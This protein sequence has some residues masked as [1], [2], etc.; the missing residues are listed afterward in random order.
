LKRSEA[1][2]LAALEDTQAQRFNE[3][4]T[5][6]LKGWQLRNLRGKQAAK[7]KA[8]VEGMVDDEDIPD[9]PEPDP[10]PANVKGEATS[11]TTAVLTWTP[12]AGKIHEVGRDPF[13]GQPA[14]WSQQVP[15]TTGMQAFT[16][17]APGVPVVLWVRVVGGERVAVTVTPTG[18]VQP[19]PDEP[20]EPDEPDVPEPPVPPVGDAVVLTV[21][22]GAPTQQTDVYALGVCSSGYG[23]TPV[24][25]PEQAAAERQLD[26]RFWRLPVRLSGDGTQVINSAAG[27]GGHNVKPILD[28]Y[29]SWGH[30]ALIVCAGR[31]ADDW[32]TYQDGD[33]GRIRAI[34]GTDQVEFTGPN[35]IGLRGQDIG[36][37]NARVQQMVAETGQPIGGP[38]WTHYD[39]GTL[40]AFMDALPADKVSTVD[41][42]NYAMGAG[43]IPPEQALA[44]TPDWGRQVREVKADMDARGIQGQPTI[45]ELNYSWRFNT[46]EFFTAVN[47]V[48]MA[49]ALGH[50]L[51]NGGRGMPYATQNGALGVTVEKPPGAENPDN[52]PLSSPMP[53]FWGIAAWTGAQ[54]F[55]H[56]KD[57]FY[58]ATSPDPLVEVFAVSNEAGGVN[59]LVINKHAAAKT[60]S[61]PGYGSAPRWTTDPAKPYDPPAQV[62]GAASWTQPG[63]SWSV[64][65]VPPFQGE[66]TS[67]GRSVNASGLCGFDYADGKSMFVA[68]WAE[69]TETLSDAKAIGARIVRAHTFG[70]TTFGPNCL[71]RADGALNPAVVAAQDWALAEAERLGIRLWAVGT[72]NW[73]WWNGTK[74]H[75]SQLA[76]GGDFYSAKVLA[77]YQRHWGEFLNRRNPHTGKLYKDHAAFAVMESGNELYGAPEWWTAQLAAF[78]HSVAPGV[79][80]ADGDTE[81]NR[82]VPLV[83]GVD[84]VGQHFYTEHGQLPTDIDR[85]VQRAH[86]AGK[87]YVV[88]EWGVLDPKRAEW[89][90]LFDAADGSLLWQLLPGNYIYFGGKAR[91][92]YY[93]PNTPEQSAALADLSR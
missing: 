29:R 31:G 64:V 83:P 9:E 69:I 8:T 72:D 62:P 74:D 63:H 24:A 65:V 85:Q 89:L 87:R 11:P 48:W 44:A 39:R 58:R 1:D 92:L 80:F 49:S 41:W 79:L 70:L 45:D 47:V 3:Q 50:I 43:V 73:S 30:R 32:G 40:R 13:A 53:A 25:S 84:I 59:V 66:P 86:D 67:F 27:G 82:D 23:R 78:H 46:G 57:Q 7:L 81:C 2:E 28:L 52:R 56:Y 21:D 34:L 17:L 35:E 19:P 4:S 20:D 54:L 18:V 90:P 22:L 60:V 38:V 16:L 51:A 88:G 14:A 26:A 36:A 15:S 71:I 55:P 75:F 5:A 61:L 93:P 33:Y 12:V 91:A 37:Y 68:T 42:H 76:G 10:L 6:G 77:V